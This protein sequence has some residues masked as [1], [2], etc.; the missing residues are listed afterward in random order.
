MTAIVVITLELSAG[1][2]ALLHSY[3][4]I[5]GILYTGLAAVFLSAIYVGHGRNLWI[6][7]IAHGLHDTSGMF[8]LF[9]GSYNRV[10]H[11]L[12]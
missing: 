12:F 3:Q 6:P 11:F 1:Y 9:L 2:F 10:V 8:F 7:I 4:G 5:T